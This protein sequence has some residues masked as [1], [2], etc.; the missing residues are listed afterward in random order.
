VNATEDCYDGR[1]QGPPS[2]ERR[3]PNPLARI[4]CVDPLHVLILLVGLKIG[5]EKTRVNHGS[6]FQSSLF[7]DG[8]QL[9]DR[10]MPLGARPEIQR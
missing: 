9:E 8:P 6:C 4:K 1:D 10:K 2:A 3:H 7:I 5:Q